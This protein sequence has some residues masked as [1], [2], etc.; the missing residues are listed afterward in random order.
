MKSDDRLQILVAGGMYEEQVLK[1]VNNLSGSTNIINIF[2]YI[3]V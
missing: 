2:L 3:A 1:R